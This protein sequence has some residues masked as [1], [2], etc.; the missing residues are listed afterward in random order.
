MSPSAFL[1]LPVEL[2]VFV[3]LVLALPDR[4]RRVRGLVVA[5]AGLLLG[6]LAVF[7]LLDLGFLARR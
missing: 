5:T 6:V 7:K 3:A 4:A 1:R 2:V